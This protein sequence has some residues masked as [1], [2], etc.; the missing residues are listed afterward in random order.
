L[1]LV[2][3][4]ESLDKEIKMSSE[5][6]KNISGKVYYLEKIALEPNSS[7]SVE[8]LDVSLA[9]APAKRIAMHVTPNADIA[10]L[11][12]T[13]KYRESDVLPGHSYA[14]SARIAHYTELV[15]MTTENHPV[16]LD[17]NCVQLQEVRVDP[18]CDMPFP[19]SKTSLP[20]D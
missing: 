16:S 10:G 17:G 4:D 1:A 6:A 7:L 9:D 14:I 8:L 18:V 3:F 11:D 5:Q 12:F 19:R 2:I 13:L 20:T 15:Y